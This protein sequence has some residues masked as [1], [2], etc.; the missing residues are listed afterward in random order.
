MKKNLLKIAL[1]SFVAMF[2]LTSCLG[3]TETT[4]TL[5]NRY[6]YIWENEGVMYAYTDANL[7]ITNEDLLSSGLRPGDCAIVA[8]KF[9][10]SNMMA[11]GIFKADYITIKEDGKFKRE[12]HVYSREFPMDTIQLDF[13]K[14]HFFNTIDNVTIGSPTEVWGN[15]RF[16]SY[17][18]QLMEGEL[19]PKLI[20]SY[21][22]DK[23][24]ID[25][26]PKK[27]T[28]IIDLQLERRSNFPETNQTLKN[29][30]ESRTVVIDLTTIRHLVEDYATNDAK[31]VDIQFRYYKGTYGERVDGVYKTDPKLQRISSNVAFDYKTEEDY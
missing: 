18:Y 15:K 27:R 10:A 9:N 11:N 2:I 23:Q 25:T 21:D 29:G 5:T 14:Y 13:P 30:Y 19:D 6:A 31:V 24:P 3:D 20:V 26:D 22:P 17:T 8:F 12:D 1:S 16:F 4:Q 28:R 7:L